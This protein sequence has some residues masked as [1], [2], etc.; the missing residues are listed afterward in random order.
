MYMASERRP[1][2]RLI[3]LSGA[4]EAKGCELVASVA[5]AH[6]S[7]QLAGRH[8]AIVAWPLVRWRAADRVVVQKRI[9]QQ[10]GDDDVMVAVVARI[11]SA[12]QAAV[13]HL[14]DHRVALS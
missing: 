1:Q 4:A 8:D 9:A 3:A 12:R 13:Y 10:A 2:S 11:F 6:R 14:D 5:G 7:Q